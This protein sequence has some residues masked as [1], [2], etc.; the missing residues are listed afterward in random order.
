MKVKTAFA[1]VVLLFIT[2]A[3]IFA[4]TV[5][6]QIRA[7]LVPAMPFGQFAQALPVAG[8]IA[9]LVTAFLSADR[10]GFKRQLESSPI[11]IRIFVGSVLVYTP[12]AVLLHTALYSDGEADP[13]NLFVVTAI[14][15]ALGALSLAIL[16]S[17]LWSD[18]VQESELIERSRNSCIAATLLCG[19]LAARH[20]GLFAPQHRVEMP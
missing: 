7:W 12:I 16:H 13:E 10:N 9:A 4:A 5:I 20:A 8:F 14:T 1:Y 17:V 11:W 2:D 6:F 18:A 19:Y 3:L 15:L